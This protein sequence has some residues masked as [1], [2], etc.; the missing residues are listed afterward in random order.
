MIEKEIGP[1]VI[2]HMDLLLRRRR[3]FDLE[4]M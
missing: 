4:R 3:S 1:E 2:Y